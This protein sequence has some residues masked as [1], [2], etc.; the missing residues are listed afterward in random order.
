[1][2]NSLEAVEAEAEAEA[3]AIKMWKSNE[4]KLETFELCLVNSDALFEWQFHYA[5]K[6]DIVSVGLVHIVQF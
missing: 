2:K 4:A 5:I 1:M 3:A 6:G